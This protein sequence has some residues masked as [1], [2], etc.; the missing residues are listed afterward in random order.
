MGD[1]PTDE[2]VMREEESYAAE[3]GA[4]FGEAFGERLLATILCEES[5]EARCRAGENSMTP[6]AI[7][8]AARAKI[9]EPERWT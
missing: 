6:S 4:E 3:K 7:L 8:R 2:E 5:G 9:A 1:D